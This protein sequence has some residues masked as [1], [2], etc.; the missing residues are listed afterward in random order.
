MVFIRLGYMTRREKQLLSCTIIEC[1]STSLRLLILRKICNRIGKVIFEVKK[2]DT[3][4]ISS[5]QTLQ[6]YHTLYIFSIIC[7]SYMQRFCRD[8]PC[9]I[10]KIGQTKSCHATCQNNT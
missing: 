8:K 2:V 4:V 5:V 10:S 9:Y 1:L 6:K 7:T 3:L